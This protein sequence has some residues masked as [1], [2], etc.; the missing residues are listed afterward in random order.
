[1]SDQSDE[2][3]K[4]SIVVEENHNDVSPNHD[5]KERKRKKHKKREEDKNSPNG[6]APQPEKKKKRRY[7]IRDAQLYTSKPI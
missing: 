4:D 2:V 1:M 7:R 6:S 5:V 3:V